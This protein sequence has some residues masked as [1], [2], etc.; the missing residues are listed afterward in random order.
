MDNLRELLGNSRPSD[1]M[2]AFVKAVTRSVMEYS[3]PCSMR[4]CDGPNPST[5]K[6]V[7]ILILGPLLSFVSHARGCIDPAAMKCG[8]C[9]RVT[10]WRTPG[11]IL[12]DLSANNT[13][14]RSPERE[15]QGCHADV[16]EVVV[17]SLWLLTALRRSSTA[18]DKDDVHH[19]ET[20]HDRKEG[21]R[22]HLV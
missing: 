20:E 19:D 7:L 11:S 1:H 5:S 14:A 13:G 9:R 22:Q 17:D 2:A 10:P 6:V 16:S 4:A 3:D 21:D 12:Y 18:T 8:R 15:R